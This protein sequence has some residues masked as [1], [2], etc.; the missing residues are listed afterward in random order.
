MREEEREREVSTC[1][2][3]IGTYIYISTMI[4]VIANTIHLLII[5]QRRFPAL[6]CSLA[7]STAYL[8]TT[9][10]CTSIYNVQCTFLLLRIGYVQ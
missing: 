9:T 2:V 1:V 5:K 3:Y 6:C 4:M 8:D 7:V 10:T